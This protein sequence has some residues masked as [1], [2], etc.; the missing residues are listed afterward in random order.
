MEGRVG[1]ICAEKGIL[2]VLCRLRGTSIRL[3]VWMFCVE[4]ARG[5]E[6]DAGLHGRE[7]CMWREI[8]IV[9]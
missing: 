6:V 1:I 7:E 2:F 4:E 9:S 3:D 8:I 5:K